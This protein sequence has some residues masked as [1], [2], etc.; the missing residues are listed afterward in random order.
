MPLIAQ[1]V[2]KHRAKI[3]RWLKGIRLGGLR[4]SVQDYKNAKKRPR[5]RKVNPYI[6]RRVLSIRRKYHD[7]CGEK[8]VYWL[9]MG[10][11][12]SVAAQCIASSTN[13][14]SCEPKGREMGREVLY[15]ML[16]DLVR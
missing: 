5:Q 4:E 2:G 14:Y 11:F 3:Y 7:R 13:T 16:R 12:I 8:I 15:L 6:E 9:K 10:V 1:R